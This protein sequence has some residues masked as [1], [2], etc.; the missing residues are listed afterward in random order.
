MERIIIHKQF[1]LGEQGYCGSKLLR[2]LKAVQRREM[3]TSN[4][5]AIFLTGSFFSIRRRIYRR[6][7]YKVTCR[8]EYFGILTCFG[9]TLL[10]L[11]PATLVIHN[12]LQFMNACCFFYF[13]SSSFREA[14]VKRSVNLSFTV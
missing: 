6:K 5:S 11:L 1:I 14:V 4:K 3:H 12:L 8:S 2:N 10:I 13:Q 9:H 7:S